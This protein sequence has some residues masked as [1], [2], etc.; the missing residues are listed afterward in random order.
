[1]DGLLASDAESGPCGMRG[2]GVGGVPGAVA[3]L[4]GARALPEPGRECCFVG[5]GC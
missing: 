2:G 1:M 5:V 3:G 4:L